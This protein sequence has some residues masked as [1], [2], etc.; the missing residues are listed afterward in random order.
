MEFAFAVSM[1]LIGFGIVILVVA[2]F[3]HIVYGLKD[4]IRGSRK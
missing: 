2:G 3:V 1:T 4:F